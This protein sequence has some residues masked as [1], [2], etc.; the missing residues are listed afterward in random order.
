[1]TQAQYDTLTSELTTDPLGRGYSGMSDAAVLADLNTAY[2]D[3]WVPVSGAE[4]FEALNATEFTAL[5][6]GDRARVDRILSLSIGSTGGIATAPGSQARA[7]MISV[8]GGGSA[9]ITA[10]AAIA[11]Q[12]ITRA[13]ELGLAGWVTVGRIATARTP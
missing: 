9:T 13:A 10:L 6:P 5:S 11:N 2:R 4:M 8:F 7:E 1:M 12:Q 3:N